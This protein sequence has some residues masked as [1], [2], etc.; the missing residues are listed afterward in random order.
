[1]ATDAVEDEFGDFEQ[2]A[3]NEQHFPVISFEP[4]QEAQEMSPTEEEYLEHPS[5]HVV[6][7]YTDPVPVPVAEPSPQPQKVAEEEK[8]ED[9]DDFGDF[10]G[11]Q[12]AEQVVVVEQVEDDDD[13]FDDF[14]VAP[15]PPVAL[16][17]AQ[18]EDDVQQTPEIRLKRLLN[19]IFPYTE[20]VAVATSPTCPLS[21][22]SSRG[23]LWSYVRQLDSTPALSFQWRHSTAHQRFLNSLKIDS[24]QQQ[25]NHNF[26]LN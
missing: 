5:V 23:A 6:S 2:A 16:V 24:I 11:F 26:I 18:E 19:N 9:A 25:V 13:E 21:P 3:I 1:V 22:L 15:P 7:K 20:P 12:A 8:E 4:L 14:E 17:S 10:T